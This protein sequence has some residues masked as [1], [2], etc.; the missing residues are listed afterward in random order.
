MRPALLSIL[1]GVAVLLGGCASADTDPNG[2]TPST[3]PWNQP[4]DSEKGGALGPA[5]GR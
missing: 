3:I 5:L 1:W 2:Q 4:T